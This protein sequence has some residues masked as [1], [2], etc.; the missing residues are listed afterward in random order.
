MSTAPQQLHDNRFL[1][2][3]WPED[4]KSHEVD[5]ALIILNGAAD[6]FM[7]QLWQTAKIRICADGAANCLYDYFLDESQRASYIPYAVVGDFDSIRQPVMEYYRQKG[8]HIQHEPDQDTT[9]MEKSVRYLDSIFKGDSSR[10]SMVVFFGGLSG[11]LDHTF[12]TFAVL[13]KLSDLFRRMLVV[14]DGNFAELLGSGS[15]LIHCNSSLE[16]PTC[17]LIPLGSPTRSITTTGLRWNMTHQSMAFGGLVSTSNIIES[18]SVE[19]TTSDPVLWTTVA[20][21]RV[22]REPVAKPAK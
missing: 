7:L 9:D 2:Y 13:W 20:S 16:G 12:A 15:H 22:A 18:E 1:S 8:S 21:L 3:L 17:G 11:R 6:P 10:P 19:V 14:S 5:F 4:A